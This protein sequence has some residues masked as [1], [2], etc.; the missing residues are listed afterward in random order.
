M[1]ELHRQ[2][3]HHDAAGDEPPADAA[4]QRL[5]EQMLQRR[6]VRGSRSLIIAASRARPRPVP[7]PVS[8]S[9]R[10]AIFRQRH[11]RR[12]VLHGAVAVV[13]AAMAR[14]PEDLRLAHPTRRDSRDA[15]RWSRSR[16]PR[17][18]GGLHEE[19]RLALDD[20]AK[21]VQPRHRERDRRRLVVGEIEQAR[22]RQSSRPA[23]EPSTRGPR[24]RR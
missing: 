16:P 22:R 6:P 5:V 23:C 7:A 24:R 9:I 18:F 19:N 4:R 1:S 10:V 20:L 21:A 14:T 12:T 2:Q 13:D 3:E 15:C 17:A 8:P 11:R